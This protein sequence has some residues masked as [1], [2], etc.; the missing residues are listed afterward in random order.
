[1]IDRHGR[2]IQYL[3][4]S[5]TD[6][7]NLSCTY[8]NPPEARARQVVPMLPSRELL[9]LEE[10]ELVV[11]AFSGLGVKKVRLTG[12]EPLLRRGIIGLSEDLYR[13]P[14]IAE[15]CITTNGVLLGEYAPALFA[16]GLRHVNISLDTLRPERFKEITGKDLF[17]R[18]IEGIDRVIGLGF[19]PVKINTVLLKEFN[20]DEILDFAKMTI[21]RRLE[22]RFIEY[23][24]IGAGCRWSRRHVFTV[25]EARAAI[26]RAFGPLEE[27][28]PRG[29]WHG[30]A[31]LFRIRGARGLLG[32]ISPMTHHFC[33]SCNR[34]RLTPDGRLRLCLFSDHEINLK[35]KVRAGISH[36]ELVDFL[37]HAVYEKPLGPM[38]ENE[39]PGCTRF[40]RT[41][42]G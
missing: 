28:Y 32:F 17:H 40:M 21:E 16:A 10:I 29:K 1:M 15:V 13:I 38:A 39:G 30:P 23:M 24:P 26:E 31:R 27:V 14:G 22:W 42:G 8:C 33:D 6:R 11:R 4:V 5:L 25:D 37:K 3:R 7:C 35:E 20:A 34:V 2:T 36:D 12:G 9:T 18:V 19:F 41:I